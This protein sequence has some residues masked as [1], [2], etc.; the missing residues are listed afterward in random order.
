MPG[1]FWVCLSNPVRELDRAA[2]SRFETIEVPDPTEEE[3]QHIL[4]T[5]LHKHKLAWDK[6]NN[7]ELVRAMW[8][9]ECWDLREIGRLV[10]RALNNLD[11]DDWEGNLEG[12]HAEACERHKAPFLGVV[13]DMGQTCW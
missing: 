12:H 13:R 6:K 1:V 2:L 5:V 11:L 7:C 8:K 9:A 3:F 4:Q 10:E